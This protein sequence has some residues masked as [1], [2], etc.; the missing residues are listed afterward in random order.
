M[1]KNK[2]QDQK[3]VSRP[4]KNDDDEGNFK[5]DITKDNAVDKKNYLTG[6]KGTKAAKSARS[7]N[8]QIL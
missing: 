2:I 6:E 4:K 3:K 5:M 1:A 8:L 7:K